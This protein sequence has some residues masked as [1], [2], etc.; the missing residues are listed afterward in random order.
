MRPNTKG[1][2]R[3]YKKERVLWPHFSR[4]SVRPPPLLHFPR[5][6]SFPPPLFVR[7]IMRQGSL[8]SATRVSGTVVSLFPQAA[9]PSALLPSPSPLSPIHPSPLPDPPPRP[10]R[11][12]T[13]S[14]TI[15]CLAHAT[16]QDHVALTFSIRLPKP[17]LSFEPPS[18]SVFPLSIRS[19]P[20]KL[21]FHLRCART[22]RRPFHA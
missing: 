1:T 16:D 20:P 7:V 21:T 2:R 22:G 3:P 12:L 5:L 15:A 19:A 18:L 11:P 17:S 4:Q 8:N 13:P 6:P 14:S 10:Q 9:F